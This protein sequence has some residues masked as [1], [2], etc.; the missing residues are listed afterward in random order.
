MKITHLLLSACCLAAAFSGCKSI[1]VEKFPDQI[2]TNPKTGEV[3]VDADGN[4]FL[5]GGWSVDYF[6]HWNWQ[7]FDSLHAKA[8]EAELDLNGY[9][10]GAAASNLVALVSTSLDGVATIT[11]KVV[12]AIVTKG[13]SIA[14]EVG[15]SVIQ[16]A[17][18]RFIAKG[19]DAATATVTCEDG[20]CTIS[21]A[22]GV[23]E[24]CEGCCKPTSN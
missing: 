12:K 1:K 15:T 14:G 4:P 13:A 10:G 21:D 3:I 18:E 11:E 24:T 17:A 22:A 7:R 2:A 16:Q 5:F 19:G 8:G 23:S 20:D 9:E 6:Q